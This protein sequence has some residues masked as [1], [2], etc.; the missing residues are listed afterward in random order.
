MTLAAAS[1]MK[2]RLTDVFIGNRDRLTAFNVGH[3]TF[4]DGVGDRMLYLRLIAAQKALA[5]NH[6]FILAVQSPINEIGHISPKRRYRLKY[7]VNSRMPTRVNRAN[8]WVDAVLVTR[9]MMIF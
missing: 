4:I 9:I 3:R 1:L 5:V 7:A 2:H 8:D 6:A